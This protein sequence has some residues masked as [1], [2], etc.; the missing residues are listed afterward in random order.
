[1]ERSPLI[2]LSPTLLPLT[3]ITVCWKL[4]TDGKFP[5]LGSA[6]PRIAA[7][8]LGVLN[9]NYSESGQAPQVG[10]VAEN[11]PSVPHTVPILFIAAHAYE[12][13]RGFGHAVRCRH[14]TE[15]ANAL[16]GPSLQVSASMHSQDIFL[17]LRR[18]AAHFS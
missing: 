10:K 8:G 5:V 12:V 9:V 13:L 15:K 1:M 18:S 7:P 16:V 17:F 6:L 14:H 11:V 3:V 4:G 2:Y